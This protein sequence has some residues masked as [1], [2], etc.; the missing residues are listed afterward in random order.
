MAM[1]IAL[2]ATLAMAQFAARR[3]GGLTGDIYGAIAEGVEVVV[4]I[5]WIVAQEALP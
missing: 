5:A 3:L 4:L 1:A 2:I